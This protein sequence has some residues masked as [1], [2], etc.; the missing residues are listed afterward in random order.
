MTAWMRSR[1][2]SFMKDAFDVFGGGL[3]GHM[4]D[5]A[6][7]DGRCQ[8]CVAAAMMWTAAMRSSGPLRLSRKPEAQVRV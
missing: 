1:T 5:D 2:W 3:V 8:H 4:V 6:A 7:G